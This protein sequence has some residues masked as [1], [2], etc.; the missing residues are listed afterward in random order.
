MQLSKSRYEYLNSICLVKN[1][2]KCVTFFYISPIGFEV[3]RKNWY[4]ILS[5][6]GL[7]LNADK[8]RRILRNLNMS[9]YS[10]QVFIPTST[11]AK[12]FFQN[13]FSTHF[14]HWLS[15]D[16]GRIKSYGVSPVHTLLNNV[17]KF[18]WALKS[19]LQVYFVFRAK[20][21]FFLITNHFATSIFPWSKRQKFPSESHCLAGIQNYKSNKQ[22]SGKTKVNSKWPYL[23]VHPIK[24]F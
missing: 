3:K 8:L 21:D 9:S 1:I 22:A 2:F 19:I 24:Q 4:Y 7:F 15:S 10:V 13:R 16:P 17:S 14:S 23:H 5:C 12:N 11:E 6:L 20:V 18:C